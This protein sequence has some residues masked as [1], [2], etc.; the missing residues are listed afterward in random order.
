MV[1][2][3]LIVRDGGAAVTFRCFVVCPFGNLAKGEEEARLYRELDALKTHIFKLAEE[4]CRKKRFPIKIDDGRLEPDPGKTLPAFGIDLGIMGTTQ[5]GIDDADAVIVL[6]NSSNKPNVFVE[7]GWAHGLWQTPVL[8]ISEDYMMPADINNLRGIPYTPAAVSG[9]APEAAAAIAAKL[10]EQLIIRLKLGKTKK[11]FDHW[12]ET[13]L[14]RGQVHVYNRFS[15]AISKEEWSR[16]MQA[17]KKEI[18]IASTG[19]SKIGIQDFFWTSKGRPPV[20]MGLSNLLF[21]KATEGVKVTIVMYHEDNMTLGQLKRLER[22]KL[23]LARAEILSAF[24]AWSL[25][26]LQYENARLAAGNQKS[27]DFVPGG[28]FRVIQ[29]TDRHLP[30]R[31]TLTEKRVIYTAR[32]YTEAFNSGLCVDA[33]AP[34]AVEDP[35]SKSVYTQIHEELQFLIDENAGPSEDRYK[36]WRDARTVA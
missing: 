4:I 23:A 30:F 8:L 27:R 29:L 16:M 33:L 25:T 5:R 19:M 22:D 15:K 6:L 14:A 36:E 7:L 13:T 10:A 17:A 32:F 21:L 20:S 18:V 28:G 12:P 1:N 3:V 11:P 2:I 35:Y 24:E 31:A 26:R 34:Q 9:A